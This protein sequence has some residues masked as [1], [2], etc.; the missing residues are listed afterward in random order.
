MAKIGKLIKDFCSNCLYK[1]DFFSCAK[2]WDIVNS[3]SG[4]VKDEMI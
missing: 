1:V 4:E 2:L 3:A